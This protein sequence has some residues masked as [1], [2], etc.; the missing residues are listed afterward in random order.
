M[1]AEA[2]CTVHGARMCVEAH[3]IFRRFETLNVCGTCGL[4]ASEFF[5]QQKLFFFSVI[6]HGGLCHVTF[7]AC[8][9]S[10]V[11]GGTAEQQHA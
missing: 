5:R 2:R 11:W 4:S 1:R 10:V 3:A 7:F 9:S 6:M 8:K